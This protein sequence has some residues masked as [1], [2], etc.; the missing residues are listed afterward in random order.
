M[1]TKKAQATGSGLPKNWPSQIPYLRSPCYSKKLTNDAIGTLVLTKA[2]LPPGE[3]ARTIVAPFSNVKITPISDVSHPANGQYGLFASQNHPPG[4]FIL[5]YLGYV[6]DRTETDESSDY[7]LSLDREVG[8][9]VDASKMGNE[10][11]FTNDYRGV[12]SGPNAEFR[13]TYIDLGNGKVEKRMGIF[14]LRVGKSGKNL[15]GIGKGQEILV[16][17]GKGFWNERTC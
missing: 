14:V 13:D 12:S 11:R 7:D 17:Y 9:G 3:Q 5:P 10:A 15:K 4:A 6:H 16:S 8:I 1:P 2:D